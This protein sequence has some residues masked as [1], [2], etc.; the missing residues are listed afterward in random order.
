[1]WARSVEIHPP[2]GALAARGMSSCTQLEGKSAWTCYRN[3]ASSYPCRGVKC[4]EWAL[5]SFVTYK[6]LGLFGI[7]FFLVCLKLW[8]LHFHVFTATRMNRRGFWKLNAVS[9]IS[10]CQLLAW[11]GHHSH[12]AHRKLAAPAG[13]WLTKQVLVIVMRWR[14]STSEE[15]PVWKES[16]ECCSQFTWGITAHPVPQY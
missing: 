6:Y 15:D 7:L 11:A 3:S 10:V 13:P 8:G 14:G 12:K 9:V 4:A 5:W 16:K 2:C 1:M